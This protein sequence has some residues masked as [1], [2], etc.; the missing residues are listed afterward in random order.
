MA[1]IKVR[2][3]I[4]PDVVIVGAKLFVILRKLSLDGLSLINIFSPP[5]VVEFLDFFLTQVRVH[6]IKTKAGILAFL[7][8][9]IHG[10]CRIHRIH[11]VTIYERIR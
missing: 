2:P 7:S 1:K 4:Q 9:F 6:D 11:V 3:E 10:T 5:D 8:P